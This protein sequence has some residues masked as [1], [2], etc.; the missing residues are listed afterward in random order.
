MVKG[1]RYCLILQRM[2]LS[3]TLR[4][5]WEQKP[6]CVFP[7]FQFLGNRLQSPWP[8]KVLV[9][10]MLMR[11]GRGCRARGGQVKTNGAA[12]GQGPGSSSRDT[13]KNIF[14]LT[15][16]NKT[17]NKRE[18]TYLRKHSSF[19]RE[20]HNLIMSGTTQVHQETSR[21]QI[22][23]IPGLHTLQSLLANPPLKHCYK[24]LQLEFLTWLSG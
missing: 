22:K 24:T 21:G 7:H 15:C 8:S 4:G 2:K 5:S 10:T 3:R 17:P 12:W 18:I 11:E 13:H 14:E 19:W 16:R 1:I 9:Q 20:S 23:R 6:F